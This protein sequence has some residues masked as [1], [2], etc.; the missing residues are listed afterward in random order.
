ME[1]PFPMP[2]ELALADDDE[3]IADI[4]IINIIDVSQQIDVTVIDI[5]E[6]ET[7]PA[8]HRWRIEHDDVAEWAMRK[9]VKL[10]VAQETID[11]QAAVWIDKIQAWRDDMVRTDRVADRIAFFEAHLTDYARRLREADPKRKTFKYPSGKVTTTSY[12][13]KASVVNEEVVIHWAKSVGHGTGD[14]VQMTEKVML[15][16]LRAI[17][18]LVELADRVVLSCGEEVLTTDGALIRSG[19]GWAPG[20]LGTVWIGDG[21]VCPSCSC[22]ALVALVTETH[23]VVQY[24]GDD[25]PGT[26]VEPGGMH[27][28][29]VPDVS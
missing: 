23:L 22:D 3:P 29:V 21:V 6:A 20:V 8:P 7:T 24:G 5:A 18:E 25:V 16:P 11:G 15:A 1:V 14:V 17:V 13:P 27:V 19:E 12:E 28:K 10:R 4:D 26:T 9:L 2:P